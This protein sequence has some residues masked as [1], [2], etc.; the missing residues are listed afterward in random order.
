M[1][2]VKEGN[3]PRT[4]TFYKNLDTYLALRLRKDSAKVKTQQKMK[5]FVHGNG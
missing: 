1:G 3:W 2:A 4:T 5:R